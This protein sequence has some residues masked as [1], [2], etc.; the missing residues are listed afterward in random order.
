MKQARS[1]T[2]KQLSITLLVEAAQRQASFAEKM[3]KQ[4]WI[5]SPVV[6]GTLSRAIDRYSNFLKLFKLYPRTVFVP[7]LDIDLIW[8]THQCTPYQY[9][10]MCKEKVGRLINHDDRIGKSTL[11]TGFT[12]TDQ[13]YRMRFGEEYRHCNCWDC[14]TL[15]SAVLDQD[16][17]FQSSAEDIARDVQRTIAYYRA[18]EIARQAGETLLPVLNRNAKSHTTVNT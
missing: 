4:L 12:K 5:R 10:A 6:E 15:L 7:T 8:H 13:L 17:N 14:E 2:S 16:S 1:I 3:H 18:V 9:D 11:D